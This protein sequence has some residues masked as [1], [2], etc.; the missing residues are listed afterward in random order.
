MEVI[1]TLTDKELKFLQ[2]MI[3]EDRML[4]DRGKSLE[5]VVHECIE[6]AMFDEGEHGA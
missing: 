3:E 5:D 2:G 4:E 6:M 1:I